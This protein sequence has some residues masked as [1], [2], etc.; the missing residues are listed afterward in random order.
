MPIRKLGSGQEVPFYDFAPDSNLTTP[1]IILD[2]QNAM[3]TIKGY[4][5]RNSAVQVAPALPLTGTG[6][7]EVP[8][9][10]YVPLYKDGTT[11][12]IVGT[13]TRLFRLVSGAWTQIGSGYTA[14]WP[15]V[16]TQFAED[17]IATS[18]GN[19]N[20]QLATGP[21]GTFA[22]FPAAT[23]SGATTPP[24]NSPS[25]LSVAGFAVGFQNN[26]WTT[27]GAGSDLNW[28]PVG[29]ASIPSTQASTGY[30]YDF[31]GNIIASAALFRNMIL[32]KQNS[33]FML[34][35]VGSATV[36]WN[37]QILSGNTG[38]WG[39]GC[40]CQMP[41]A[42]AFLGTDDFYICQASAPQR[43]PNS[44]K[45]WFFTQVHVDA[46]GN[47]DQLNL[48][49]SWYDPLTG[50]VYW[51]YVSKTPPYANT[52]DR[53]VAWNSRS[54]RWVPGYLSTPLVVWNTQPG[55][56]SGLYFDTNGNLM[57][58]TGAPTTMYLLTGYQGDADNLTQLQKVRCSF[59][60]GYMPTSQTL[61]PMHAYRMGDYPTVESNGILAPD[62]WHNIRQTDRYHQVQISTSGPCEIQ[63]MAYEGRIA[64]VR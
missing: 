64:G 41:T 32:F 5:T 53:Y 21:T 4:K 30:L 10:A 33:M 55:R 63:A 59:T 56:Q 19:S 49:S 23:V 27:S 39:Q 26:A 54:G 60:Q 25:V 18:A 48:T 1:G 3:P 47:P 62:G 52:P 38:T 17:V 44:L 37:N 34:N 12:V 29:G 28:A 8:L 7:T 20:M 16:M 14:T 15:W 2:A 35:F 43:I 61:T 46:N 58:W 42:V 45:E 11:S 31:P 13:A 36:T 9:G 51:H 50:A 40:V 57:S 22:N 24:T 6:Q